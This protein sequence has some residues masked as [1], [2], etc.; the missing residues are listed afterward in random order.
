MRRYDANIARAYL[1]KLYLPRGA[2]W[3]SND[4][5]A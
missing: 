4:L 3:E 2:A 1:H 5:R